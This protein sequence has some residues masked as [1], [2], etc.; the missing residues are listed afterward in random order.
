M[1]KKILTQKNT[2]LLFFLFASLYLMLSIIGGVKNYSP[3]PFLD[4]WTSLLFYEEISAGSWQAWWDQHNEHRIILSRILF[5]LDL[6]L[7]KGQGPFLIICNYL[8]AGLSFF[9]FYR[10]LQ[11]VFP[12]ESDK[13]TKNIILMVIFCLLFSWIQKHNF[14]DPFQ[15]QFFLAQLVPLAAF[16]LLYKRFFIIACLAGIAAIGTM[17]N[18]VLTLP[19]MVVFAVFL[20]MK[21]WQITILLVCS[22][23]SIIV[24]FYDYRSPSQH[25]S[26]IDVLLNHPLNLIQ[27]VLL[28]LGSPVYYILHSNLVAKLAGIFLLISTICFARKAL[29]KPSSSLLQLVLLLFL[30][31]IGI[32][33]LATGGGRL[34]LGVEQALAGRYT[35]PVLMAWSALLV[36]YA[37]MIARQVNIRW[38]R[39]LPFILVP[40]LLL[41]QQLKTLYPETETLFDRKIA[42]LASK[43]GIYDY[44]ELSLLY[45]APEIVWYIGIMTGKKN[46][47]I[48]G[49]PLIK[50]A[51]LVI[52]QEKSDLLLTPCNGNID[53]IEVI[54]TDPRYIKVTGW[55]LN[56]NTGEIPPIVYIANDKNIIV[57]YA[58]TGQKRE[59][60]KFILGKKAEFSGF[61]GYIL[62]EQ[63]GPLILQGAQDCE[64]RIIM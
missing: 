16:F 52:N 63:Q 5:W 53:G 1:I 22:I 45:P 43:L 27:Y 33:A 64:L 29:R 34:L 4:M 14:I 24:Y 47:S 17:A 18:G 3:V 50:D 7:F 40:V 46:L 8:L 9:V 15:S 62:S 25:G 37:P 30:L 57:G 23:L 56:P 49:N 36:L 13:F 55:V 38:Y 41:P 44:A 54:Y 42:A 12:E 26:V 10:M 6:T 28:Y 31:Y 19:L 2:Y 32:S 61:R 20:K 11:E 35:T 39:I 60:V 51:A 59:D 48:F 58:L 21:R